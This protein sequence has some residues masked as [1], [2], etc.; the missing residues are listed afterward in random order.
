MTDDDVE[1]AHEL[2]DIASA[3]GLQHFTADVT[4]E[5]KADG[6][7]VSAGDLA[8]ERAL[9]DMI[10]TRRPEDGILTEESGA[11]RDARR[12]WILDPIDG[13]ALYVRN[14]AGWGNHI[15]LEV[16]GE[17]VLGIIT[18]PVEGHRYWAVAGRGAFVDGAPLQLSAVDSLDRSRVGFFIPPGSTLPDEVA[19]HVGETATHYGIFVEFLIGER[20]AIVCGPDCGA[21]WDHAPCGIITVEAG[22]RFNDPRGGA[23]IDMRAGL[24]SNG[25]IHDSLREVLGP[26]A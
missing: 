7:P 11:L 19:P 2:A 24:Y 3:V 6:T 23:R 9:V 13:T 25:H 26:W 17:I 16:D 8:V 4:V 1:F 10:R 14:E 12:R 20:E 18:R 22:G 21:P 5:T 15:A